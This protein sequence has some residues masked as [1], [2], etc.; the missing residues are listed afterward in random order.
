MWIKLPPWWNVN[1]DMLLLEL[2]LKHKLNTKE[3][4]NDLKHDDFYENWVEQL[5]KNYEYELPEHLVGIIWQ[6]RFK[7][8][9]QKWFIAKFLGQ[10]SE[11]NLKT[12]NP[13][14]IEWKWVAPQKLPDIIVNFKKDLYKKLLKEI[15]TLIN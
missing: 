2:A 10:D 5:E 15:Y 13:E 11:I 4:V 6:G 1:H 7:G 9:K 3:Y 12:K 8:Q 14:F